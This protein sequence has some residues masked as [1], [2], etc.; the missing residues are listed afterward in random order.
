M[1]EFLVLTAVGPDRP[2]LVDA[3]SEY[4]LE[5]G[6]NIESSRM[7]ILGGEF[8]VILLLSA[9]AEAANRIE[10]DRETLAERSGLTISLKETTE[11]PPKEVESIPYD[12]RAVSLDHPGIVHVV[13]HALAQMGINV[14]S[15]ETRTT[16]APVTGTPLFSMHLEV[17]V[18]VALAG[19]NLRST[20][21]KIGKDAGI[22]LEIRR[23]K[24]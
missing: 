4:L 14:A 15:L 11:R 6:A 12:I 2:G 3:I 5:R 13:A 10:A 22:D 16:P 8:A 1:K 23:A 19:A 21:Q 24:V 18:P 9:D 17:E 7:A 20:L